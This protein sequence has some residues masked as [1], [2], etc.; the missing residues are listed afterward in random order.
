VRHYLFSGGTPHVTAYGSGSNYCKVYGWRATEVGNEWHLEVET[1]CYNSS[2]FLTDSQYVEHL[3]A[4][5]G[6]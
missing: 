4:N 6:L 2:G 5:L 1:L 3:T